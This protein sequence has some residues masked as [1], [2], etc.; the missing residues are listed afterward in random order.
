MTER[1]LRDTQSRLQDILR[2]DYDTFVNP[3]FFLQGRADQFAQQSQQTRKEVMSSI[4]GL[5]A[6]DIY[7]ARTGD[8]RR[9]AEV[10][11]TGIE[12][13]LE[14]IG[15]EL[16]EEAP[17]RNASSASRA[18]CAASSLPALRRRQP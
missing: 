9:N 1:T 5:G 13:R 18:D 14:E 15:A 10:Q 7:K 6:W 12:G 11:L 2:L 17:R 4:L 16:A 3:S 8:R